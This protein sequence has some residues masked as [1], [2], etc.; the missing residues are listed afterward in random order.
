MAVTFPRTLRLVARWRR[1]AIAAGVALSLARSASADANGTWVAYP[2]ACYPAHM[3][4]LAAA[5]PAEQLIFLYGGGMNT[6]SGNETNDTYV[7]DLST[8]PAAFR[9]IPAAVSPF[10]PQHSSAALVRDPSRRRLLL[11]VGQSSDIV[12]SEMEVWELSLGSPPAWRRLAP[13]GPAPEP[14]VGHAAL[15]DPIRDRVVV[16]GGEPSGSGRLHLGDT[17]VLDLSPAPAWSRLDPAGAVPPALSGAAVAYDARRD[18]MMVFGG[19]DANGASQDLWTLTFTGT[20]TWSL[21]AVSGTAPRAGASAAVYDSTADRMYVVSPPASSSSGGPLS[22]TQLVPAGV[23]RW[24]SVSSTGADP[25]ARSGASVALFDTGRRLVVV[26]GPRSDAY[27]LDLTTD[28]WSDLEPVGAYPGVS[29]FAAYDSAGARVFLLGGSPLELWVESLGEPAV[30]QRPVAATPMP[31]TTSMPVVFD[32]ANG[33]LLAF[34]CTRDSA[35][36]VWEMLADPRPRWNRIS[37]SGFAPIGKKGTSFVYDPPRRRVLL[38]G[39]AAR[40]TDFPD[41]QE[42][43]LDPVPTWRLITTAGPVARHG[44]YL[45]RDAVHD[46]LALFGGAR[47]IDDVGDERWL[48]DVWTWD[49]ATD[50]G[51]KPITIPGTGLPWP[52]SGG[53]LVHDAARGRFVFAAGYHPRTRAWASTFDS[54]STWTELQASVLTSAVPAEPGFY[55]GSRDRLLYPPSGVALQF[56]PGEAP[57]LDCPPDG[58]WTAGSV[59]DVC[60][61]VTGRSGANLEY[62]YELTCSRD[63]SDFPIRGLV[64]ASDFLP[65]YVP[66]GIPVPDT[67]ASGAVRFDL[68]AVS[69]SQPDLG[70]S[71]SFS[72]DHEPAAIAALGAE[73]APDRAIVRWRVGRA[74]LDVVVERRDE[75]GAWAAI[76]SRSVAVPGIIAHEDRD[77]VPGHSY[78][79][80]LTVS[81][82]V[83]GGSYGEQRVAV[84]L[85]S[86][87]FAA[88]QPNP[89]AGQFA[90]QCVI[91]DGGEARL[92]AYDVGGRRVSSATAPA[93]SPGRVTLRLDG[94]RSLPAGV[95]FLRLTQGMQN[96]RKTVVFLR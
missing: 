12:L 64:T 94:E 51:W 92:D 53:A 35:V 55:D 61:A 34:D 63:W 70:A 6:T 2:S 81:D 3:N 57:L 67:A 50:A 21:A 91:A 89:I 72:L 43:R 76:A 10:P 85:W 30:W 87:A 24:E 11:I 33:R 28:V 32:A 60:F 79:Y 80:R 54:A 42:L 44:A 84:P 62:V 37:T 56:G 8:T 39:G 66:I 18:R 82:P 52:G 45:G 26:G 58:G 88:A 68:S 65:V 4:A 95:Y 59:R 46:R 48:T 9:H 49:L 31:T 78:F 73:A 29:G 25:G 23:S 90:V 22:L 7:L 20:P 1:L 47:Y 71:C 69:T 27:A 83:S 96:R 36:K 5:D 17:W 19:S 41:L 15:Y 40:Y 93:G 75:G 38:Y 86:L 14:R 74:G 13:V 77:V 16:Y